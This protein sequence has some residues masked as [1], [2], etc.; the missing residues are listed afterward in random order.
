MHMSQ[1]RQCT[2]HPFFSDA[3]AARRYDAF[4]PKV[5][6]SII[7]RV[8]PLLGSIPKANALDV[9]CGTGDSARVLYRIARRVVGIDRSAPMLS[10]AAEK[11]DAVR[12]LP[13]EELPALGEKFDLVSTCMA[14]H[15]FDQE[16]VIP[17]YKKVTVNGGHWL[18]YNFAFAG[19]RT[20]KAFNDAFSIYL[21]EFPSP[22]RGRQTAH[23][24]LD[25]DPELT[26]VTRQPGSLEIEMDLRGLIGYL[27]TQSNVEDKVSVVANRVRK[28]P[29][30]VTYSITPQRSPFSSTPR[31][32]LFSCQFARSRGE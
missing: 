25:S 13:V 15:W 18:I 29:L 10:Y 3:E 12:E 11:C 8:I 19:H 16:R 30:G 28:V 32:V 22:A 14:F 2:M 5:H 24:I 6:D 17:G 7:D 21:R 31:S 9:A 26:L 20:S 1:D 27:S 4:R 23:E